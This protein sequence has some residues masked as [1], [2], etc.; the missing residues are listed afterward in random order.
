MAWSLIVRQGVHTGQETL[1]ART[2]LAD[3]LVVPI[4]WS[5]DSQRLLVSE[6]TGPMHSDNV[7]VEDWLVS[8]GGGV[9]VRLEL[10]DARRAVEVDAGTSRFGIHVLGW[11]PASPRRLVFAV[12]GDEDRFLGYWTVRDDGSSTELLGKDEQAI[13]VRKFSRIIGPTPELK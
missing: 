9:P 6:M 13:R 5:P 3:R 2:R 11:S 7:S 10:A 8:P 1:V 4:D 12:R